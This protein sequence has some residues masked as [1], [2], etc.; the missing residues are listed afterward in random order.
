MVDL[1]GRDGHRQPSRWPAD[2]EFRACTDRRC[3]GPSL[4]V[5]QPPRAPGGSTER[6]S[7]RSLSYAARAT[8]LSFAVAVVPVFTWPRA[9]RRATG[10]SLAPVETDS[11]PFQRTDGTR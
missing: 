10:P 5:W 11:P 4:I 9:P 6:P 7:P 8:A 3:A 1:A 2:P